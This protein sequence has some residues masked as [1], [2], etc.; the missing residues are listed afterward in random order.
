MDLFISDLHTKLRIINRG[1]SGLATDSP[2]SVWGHGFYTMYLIGISP[3]ARSLAA[4]N[5]TLLI[6][7]LEIPFNFQFDMQCAGNANSNVS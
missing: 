1:V 6:L 3:L 5:V 7:V 4:F 2:C